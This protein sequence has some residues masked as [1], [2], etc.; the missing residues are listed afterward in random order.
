MKVTLPDGTELELPD[1]ATG[2][3]AA[4]AIGEGLARAALGIR[5]PERR[6]SCA[7]STRRSHDGAGSRSSPPRGRRTPSG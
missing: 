2:A 6:P 4:A 7:T 5:A 3:D 1:G